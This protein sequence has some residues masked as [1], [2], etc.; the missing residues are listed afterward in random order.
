MYSIVINSTNIVYT[1]TS[2]FLLLGDDIRVVVVRGVPVLGV[3]VVVVA[4]AVAL[5]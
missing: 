5:S 1:E 4:V 2:Y 3:V